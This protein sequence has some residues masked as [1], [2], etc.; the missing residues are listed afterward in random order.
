MIALAALLAGG[1]VYGEGDGTLWSAAA[2]HTPKAIIANTMRMTTAAPTPKQPNR[3][4][5]NGLPAPDD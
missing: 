2:E 1:G 3:P 5:K 4:E